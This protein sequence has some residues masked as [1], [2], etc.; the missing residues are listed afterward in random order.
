MRRFSKPLRLTT[1]SISMTRWRISAS[2]IFT[3]TFFCFPFFSTVFVN[4]P[5]VKQ[6]SQLIRDRVFRHTYTHTVGY[7]NCFWGFISTIKGNGAIVI[8]LNLYHLRARII[9][10]SA[11]PPSYVAGLSG[12]KGDRGSA[13]IRIFL[14][15]LIVAS[16]HTGN[17][18]IYKFSLTNRLT[19]IFRILPC[20]IFFIRII[21][22]NPV[23]SV[24]RKLA[25]MTESSPNRARMVSMA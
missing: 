1:S 13:S 3:L 20:E 23:G 9:C 8:R 22:I 19:G 2:G 7:L 24:F 10:F 6:N 21:Y 16:Y 4:G 25:R 15:F 18:A 11:A 12:R 17:L 5:L 14:I